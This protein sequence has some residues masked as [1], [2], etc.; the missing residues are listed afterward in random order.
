[1]AAGFTAEVSFLRSLARARKSHSTWRPCQKVSDWPKK[2]PKR[3]DM[4]GVMERLA[5]TISLIAR[6]ATPMARAMAFWRMA[7]PRWLYSSGV[8]RGDW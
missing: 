7:H 3:S 5:W 6:G 4:A 8:R 2:A 1:M